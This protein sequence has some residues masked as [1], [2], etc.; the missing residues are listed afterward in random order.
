MV[1]LSDAKKLIDPEESHS[2]VE[3]QPLMEKYRIPVQHFEYCYIEKCK[4][5]RELEKIVQVL[6]S[7]EEGYFPDLARFAENRL[8]AV[9]PKS[10]LLRSLCPVISKEALGKDERNQITSDLT[11]WVANVSKDDDELAFFKNRKSDRDSLPQVREIK[12]TVLEEKKKSVKRISSTDYSS[13]DK[14]DPD[15]EILKMDLQEQS[16]K[17][18]SVQKEKKK[19]TT[20]KTVQFKEFR[21]D[22]EALHEANYEKDKGNEFF[23]SGDYKEAL[24]HYT[25]SINCKPTLAS[26]T[27]RALTNIKLKK[28]QSAIDDCHSALAIDPDNVKS[29]L[30]KSQALEGLGRHREAFE[31]VEQAIEID[32]NNTLAQELADRFRNQCTGAPQKSTRFVVEDSGGASK[33][34]KDGV[35]IPIPGTSNM[36]PPHYITCSDDNPEKVRE[37][38]IRANTPI[39]I[40]HLISVDNSDADD[41][42]CCTVNHL[43]KICSGA[44]V[45]ESCRKVDVR[46]KNEENKDSCVTD[47]ETDSHD[48]INLQE[49]YEK[50][51]T[52]REEIAQVNKTSRV[53]HLGNS[54]NLDSHSFDSNVNSEAN[55]HKTKVENKQQ[56]TR[57]TNNVTYRVRVS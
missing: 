21:T 11:Q 1:L 23:K 29:F 22:V 54:H 8:A 36:S 34:D 38:T 16:L 5:G 24:K 39:Q 52:E 53:D 10:K 42:D 47:C 12:E 6:R 9:K 56:E 32:P 37:E 33:K 45:T 14:Y 41:D 57:R 43:E 17:E 27:N 4:D 49:I 19:S 20:K 7:G 26:F 40:V 25:N 28:F 46:E 55:E 50:I 35:I 3:K 18:S 2:K 48:K 30:R 44:S 31:T 51:P 13:W 15:T